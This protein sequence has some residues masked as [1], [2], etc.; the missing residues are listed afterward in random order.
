MTDI[1]QDWLDGL[2]HAA[3]V[4]QDDRKADEVEELL[5]HLCMAA[6]QFDAP[7][8]VAYADMAEAVARAVRDS[9]PQL[10][11]IPRFRLLGGDGEDVDPALF[12]HTADGR[13]AVW[14]SR[15]LAAAC[16]G[17]TVASD[18]LI[19]SRTVLGVD[20]VRLGLQVLIRAGAMVWGEAMGRQDWDAL[21]AM[22]GGARPVH[23]SADC[24]G[25]DWVGSGLPEEM[26]DMLQPCF[27]VNETD[28]R[29]RDL[30]AAEHVRTTRHTVTWGMR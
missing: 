3:L 20:E 11:T 4:F 15:V 16:S 1:D 7:P 23:Y 17:D 24:H 2:A 30:L 8:I 25:G 5:Q 19:A 10:L 22:G 21:L 29:T 14:S 6:G 18:A 9:H 28:R 26:R 13:A 12:E 27:S